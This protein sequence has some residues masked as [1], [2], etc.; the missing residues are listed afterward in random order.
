MPDIAHSGD[1][2]RQSIIEISY[3]NSLTSPLNVMTGWLHSMARISPFT[4]ILRLGREGWLGDVT[5][6]ATWGGLVAII[7]LSALTLTF[8]YRGL[9]KLA[10]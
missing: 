7:G 5:W 10:N 2:Q 6:Q 8:A 1:D 3:A 4:N 9:A